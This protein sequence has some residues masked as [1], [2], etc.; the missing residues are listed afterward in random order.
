MLAWLKGRFNEHPLAFLLLCIVLGFLV[1]VVFTRDPTPHNYMADVANQKASEPEKSDPQLERAAV[2]AA[3]IIAAARNP[4]SVKFYL[5]TVLSNGT[6]CYM[7]R[8]QNGFGGVNQ[9]H[10][11]LLPNAANLSQSSSVWNSRCANKSGTDMTA[12]IQQ[13]MTLLQ[14][15]AGTK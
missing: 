3:S 13:R 14:I 15:M 11:V 4:D 12:L 1:M 8:A 10:A 5:V 6:A 7:W 2:G 9:E